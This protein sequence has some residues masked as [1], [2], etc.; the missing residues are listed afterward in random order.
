MV[1]TVYTDF[2]ETLVKEYSLMLLVKSMLAFYKLV[3]GK[4]FAL[5]LL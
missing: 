4:A 3:F 1:I 5:L 2:D